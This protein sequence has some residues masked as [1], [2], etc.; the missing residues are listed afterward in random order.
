MRWSAIHDFMVGD[1][2]HAAAWSLQHAVFVPNHRSRSVGDLSTMLSDRGFDVDP[3]SAVVD[4]MTTLV[5][6]QRA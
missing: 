5:V 6:G 1:G 4:E 2:A 3:A